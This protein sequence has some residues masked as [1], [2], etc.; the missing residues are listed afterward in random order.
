MS[1]DPA[2]LRLRIYPDPVLRSPAKPI[3]Y[4]ENV[5]AVALRML[6]IMREEE[7]IGLAAPQVG[8]QWRMF[9]TF[10][11]EGDRRSAEADPPS[12]ETSP[13]VY[14]NPVLVDAAG[15]LKGGEEGCLSL[16][17]IRG[18]VHRP[19]LITV[20]ALDIDGK[21]FERRGAG[22]LARCW[23]HETDHLDG[24]LILDRMVQIYRLKNKHAVRDLEE[25]W[26]EQHRS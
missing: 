16:P 8:L 18:V 2:S 15:P 24:T 20:R 25:T 22:L 4:N 26:D 13:C 14:I 5:R 3:V 23:Q 6:E 12:A 19:E 7:G 11:P 17:S 9:V 1:V 21:P 10:V